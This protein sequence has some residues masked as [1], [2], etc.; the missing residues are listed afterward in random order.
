MNL[1]QSEPVLDSEAC[2]CL[3]AE[4]ADGDELLELSIYSLDRRKLYS[5][6]FKPAHR[7]TWDSSIH[8]ITPQM[9]ADAPS[10]ASELP[11][12]RQIIDHAS[13]LIG[14][15]IDNDISHLRSQGVKN[16]SDKHII[17]LRDWYW[18]N[19][20]LKVGLDLFQGVSLASVVE[21]LQ[22]QFGEEGMHSADGD[23]LA[24][25]DSFLLLYERFRKH[26]NINESFNRTIELFDDE[27]SREKLEYDRTHAEGYAFLLKM[28]EGYS[29]R[30]K[31][32][33]PRKT[34]RI[35]AIIKVADRQ[36]AGV[37]LRNMLGKRPQPA[38]GIY[39]LRESDIE[40]FSQYANSFDSDEHAIFKK[41]QGLSSRFN[42]SGL[43][44]R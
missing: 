35:A 44:K 16:L 13:H 27:Y 2:V 41:L 8:H 38:K 6:R 29:L 39:S 34:S 14:F 37:E 30:I 1:Q 31:R 3:D 15:A 43:K 40:R 4:F 11:K 23:T 25:L 24:T 32:E 19:H 42:V 28:N 33:E 22:L 5:S 9:V 18:I 7:S 12:V 17:E 21:T 26:R 20:G 10:F 36:R